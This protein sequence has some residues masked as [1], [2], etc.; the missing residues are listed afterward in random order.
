VKRSPLTRH[1]PLRRKKA[2]AGRKPIQGAVKGGIKTA[3]HFLPA[4]ACIAAPGCEGRL[5]RHHIL[6]VQ[7]LRKRG[8]AHVADSPANLAPLCRRHHARHHSRFSPVPLELV[9]EPAQD[10][11]ASLGLAWLL[12]RLYPASNA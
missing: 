9:P 2:L 10:F 11:A 7:Q 4:S 3:P 6:P 1:T 8:L 12:E 5:D